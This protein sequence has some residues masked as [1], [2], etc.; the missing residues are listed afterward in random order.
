MRIMNRSECHRKYDEAGKKEPA[1]QTGKRVPFGYLNFH[2]YPII[3]R[4]RLR[5]NKSHLNNL[6]LSAALTAK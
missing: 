1:E 3:H 6:G 5:L 2:L 4:H